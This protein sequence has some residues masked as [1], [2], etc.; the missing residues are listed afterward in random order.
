MAELTISS[1]EIR[2]ALE[3]YVSSY[4]PEISR[5]EVGIVTDA[6]DGIAHV[7]GLPSTMAN[8]LLEFEDGTLGVALNLDVR[9]IGVV[10]LG[11]VRRH[12]GG[13]AGQAHRPGALGAGRRRLPRPRGRPAGQADRRSRRDRRTR[14]SAS[15]SCRRR[16]SWRASR[17]KEPL[18]TGIK[19]IDA[20][21]ADRPWPAPADHRRPQDRQDHGR[22]RH[23][24]Q[25]ARQLGVRRPGQAG[26]LHLRRDRPE[27]LH[28]RRRCEGTL[29]EARRDGVH[30]HRRVAR[31]PTRP[32][33]STSR[34]TPARPSASTGCTPA[35]TS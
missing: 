16:T 30:D 34:R 12:R 32:A 17:V 5:E 2:G 22:D 6:G 11:D 23:D 35:S 4:T 10:V 9:E 15:W 18:Q 14:A 20:M 8:E 27:G 25:P 26:P 24:P 29:E 1:D 33:S 7:E 3:R 28:H 21:T 13:P 19:A 31:R